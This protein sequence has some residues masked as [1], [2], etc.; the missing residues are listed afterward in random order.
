MSER[1]VHP[2]DDGNA[3][4]C[5][6]RAAAALCVATC[7]PVAAQTVAAWRTVDTPPLTYRGSTWPTSAVVTPLLEYR[8]LGWPTSAVVTPA[9]EYRGSI[10][11]I[12]A[13]VTQALEY[14]GVWPVDAVS[15][16]PLAFN[17]AAPTKAA[18]PTQPRLL[19][20]P[21]PAPQAPATESAPKPLLRSP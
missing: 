3:R 12:G 13:V 17:G 18:V 19:L 8:G 11:P 14:R 5:W 6:R 4:R 16:P 10:W 1:R 9:L 7:L 15:T 21:N 2:R 20:R